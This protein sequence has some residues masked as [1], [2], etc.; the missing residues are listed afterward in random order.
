[1][2]HEDEF[3]L[4][5]ADFARAQKL[6][7]QFAGIALGDGKRALVYGRLVPRLRQQGL[8]RVGAYLERVET[9]P[10]EREHFINSLTTNVTDFFREKH[11]FE[12]LR[13]SILPRLYARGGPVHIWS[14]GC[15]SGEEP[16]TI[17]LTVLATPPPSSVTVKI[18]AADLDSNVVARAE[19]GVYP[20]SKLDPVPVEDRQ[21]GFLKGRG[22][23]SGFA[24]A[25]PE[26]KALVHF[27]QLNLMAAWPMKGLFDVIFCR[28]V[29]IYFDDATRRNLVDRFVSQLAPGGMLM[30]GHSE[31]VIGVHPQL[32]STGHTMFEKRSQAMERAA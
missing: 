13:T 15:S 24:C 11:H 17:G 19:E 31:A 27:R 32:R 22:A 18:L 10:L 3:E 26:L 20:L 30:L 4:S 9:D 12:A 25:R 14:A 23:Q 16:Y 2:N 29:M 28:N 1:M 5:D 7:R 21:R 8:K 6:I